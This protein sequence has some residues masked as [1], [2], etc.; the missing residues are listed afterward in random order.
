VPV[1]DDAAGDTARR[2]ETSAMNGRVVEFPPK[3]RR[4]RNSKISIPR[5]YVFYF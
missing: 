2:A 4:S 5:N 3:M 1:V